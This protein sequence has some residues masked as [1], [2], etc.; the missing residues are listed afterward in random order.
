MGMRVRWMGW[1]RVPWGPLLASEVG[2]AQVPETEGTAS[3]WPLATLL[4][5]RKPEEKN[6]HVCWSYVFFPALSSGPS[7]GRA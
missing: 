7:S 3:G 2:W 5:L 6:W 1:A 4:S